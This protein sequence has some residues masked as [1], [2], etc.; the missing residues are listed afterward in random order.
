MHAPFIIALVNISR[1]AGTALTALA[2]LTALT[3]LT[4][5]AQ[6]QRGT[7]VDLPGH[8]GLVTDCGK[9]S[10]ASVCPSS[11]T[12]SCVETMSG[13][14]QRHRGGGGGGTQ[15]VN[16]SNVTN[17]FVLMDTRAKQFSTGTRKLYFHFLFF[18]ET[19]K[20]NGINYFRYLTLIFKEEKA[21]KLPP[22]GMK[23][24]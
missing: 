7:W 19:T 12:G 6:G 23:C 4:A 16:F 1:T 5:A 14:A 10:S 2:A 9:F 15:G 8:V 3:A 13:D 18:C 22:V 21:K 20:D 17:C 24:N 11:H